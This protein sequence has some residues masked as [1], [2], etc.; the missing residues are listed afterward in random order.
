[1]R[2]IYILLI[3][4]VLSLVFNKVI[5][6]FNVTQNKTSI[7]FPPH[8]IDKLINNE[9]YKKHLGLKTYQRNNSKFNLPVNNNFDNIDF[10]NNY[11]YDGL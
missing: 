10:S 1:M 9:S 7:Y 2:I 5:E 6:Q 4:L 3:I 8:N 11:T